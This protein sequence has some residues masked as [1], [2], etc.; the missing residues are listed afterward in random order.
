MRPLA[1]LE[2]EGKVRDQIV[3]SDLESAAILM[4]L[5]ILV[6][7][8]DNVQPH[9]LFQRLEIQF[10]VFPRALCAPDG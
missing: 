10:N 7:K 4:I 3:E 2:L 8:R 1:V 9:E 6:G 5:S